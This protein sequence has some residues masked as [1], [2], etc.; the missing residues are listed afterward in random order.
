MLLYS[1]CSDIKCLGNTL[2]FVHKMIPLKWANRYEI[3]ICSVI[4]L[5]LITLL[6]FER[7]IKENENMRVTVCIGSC[8]HIKGSRSVVE[9][10]Q[11]LIESNSLTE[12]VSLGGTFCLGRCREGI[13]VLIDDE[14]FSV[15]P[16]TTEEFFRENI[17][18]KV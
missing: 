8:C 18:A 4:S 10:L 17:L 7:K 15:T 14:V 3:K 16:Q 6:F 5:R 13:S 11:A 2:R 1:G 9:Q 12:K